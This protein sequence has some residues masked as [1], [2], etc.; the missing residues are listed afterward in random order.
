M[1]AHMKNRYP[2]RMGDRA[3]SRSR[4]ACANRMR[5]VRSAECIALPALFAQ[6]GASK[7]FLRATRNISLHALDA[8]RLAA[9][10][11][12]P[13]S[14]LPAPGSHSVFSTLSYFS[15]AA[16]VGTTGWRSA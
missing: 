10:S 11:P 3:L 13:D 14:G 9:S 8:V 15:D 12:S 2:L 6:A 1:L 7:R 4:I 5:G 16:R